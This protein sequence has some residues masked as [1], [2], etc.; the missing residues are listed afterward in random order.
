VPDDEVCIIADP[1]R[2]EQIE[3][4]LLSNALK[5]AG[6]GEIELAIER[7]A[8][9]ARLVVRDHGIGIPPDML[10]RIFEPF[11]RVAEDEN[12]QAPTVPGMGLGLAL[13][14]SIVRGHGGDVHAASAGRGRGAEL[15][16]TLPLAG[17]EVFSGPG[18]DGHADANTLVLVEDQDDSREMLATLLEHAGFAVHA[19]ANG[20][21]AVDVIRSARPQVAVIDIGLPGI[22]GREVARR[23]R[24]QGGSTVFM[25]ALTGYGQQQDRESV[26][27]AGFDQHLVKPVDADTLLEVIRSRLRLRLESDTAAGA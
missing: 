4:N 7:D 3:V 2:I 20:E 26:L 16:V 12:G 8:D 5:Y 10:E 21:E 9:N 22:D 18:R 17:A 27:R 13:V 15:T 25:V 24:E 23:V 19:V 6:H 14:R 1:D 11:V